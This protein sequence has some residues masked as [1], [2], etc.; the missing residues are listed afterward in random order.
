M[1]CIH[2]LHGKIVMEWHS[3]HVCAE[4]E[5]AEE[6]L[7][8]HRRSWN[9]GTR[10]TAA[11]THF[12]FTQCRLRSIW[13]NSGSQRVCVYKALFHGPLLTEAFKI[14]FATTLWP[15]TSWPHGNRLW[16]ELE[17]WL[18]YSVLWYVYVCCCCFFSFTL[19]CTEILRGLFNCYQ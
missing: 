17:E 9:T 15:V 18:Y 4:F 19:L 12:I 8:K 14:D 3:G 11:E 13:R 2:F 1:Y 7:C 16:R 5:E 6:Q 10:I